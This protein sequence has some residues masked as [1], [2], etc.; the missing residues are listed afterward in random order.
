[1]CIHVVQF[2]L[3]IRNTAQQFPSDRHADTYL[4]LLW[5]MHVSHMFFKRQM[6]QLK[7]G[8]HFHVCLSQYR[9]YNDINFQNVF[10]KHFRVTNSVWFIIPDHINFYEQLNYIAQH[11]RKHFKCIFPLQNQ[12]HV[13][14]G[15]KPRVTISI[16]LKST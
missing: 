16:S 2:V 15:E 14:Q 8:S 13:D 1:M 10:K 5:E 12:S 6:Y 7:V 9:F 3:R 11:V 4:M